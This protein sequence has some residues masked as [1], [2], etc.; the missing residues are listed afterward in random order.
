M[1][2]QGLAAQRPDLRAQD[3]P[4]RTCCRIGHLHRILLRIVL[5]A[6]LAGQ[7]PPAVFNLSSAQCT[8]IR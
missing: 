4:I 3:Q 1:R 8:A 2:L 7:L 6:Y 5:L